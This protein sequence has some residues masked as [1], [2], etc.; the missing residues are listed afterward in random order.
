MLPLLYCAPLAANV[1]RK[2]RL[3]GGVQF[4]TG[5][6]AARAAEPAS[7]FAAR[8]KVS[9]SGAMPEPTVTVR[10]KED[11]ASPARR[12]AAED[13]VRARRAPKVGCKA[14]RFT[15]RDVFLTS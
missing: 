2:R 10:M 8:Q 5:G 15:P 12:P 11:G 1:G 4:P 3:Q 9:R 6:M 13:A 14:G 7:A